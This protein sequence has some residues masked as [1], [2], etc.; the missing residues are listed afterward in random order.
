MYS[1][2]LTQYTCDVDY[3]NWLFWWI[4]SHFW[5]VSSSTSGWSVHSLGIVSPVA[6][7]NRGMHYSCISIL[8]RLDIAYSPRDSDVC[9]QKMPNNA[10]TPQGPIE[11]NR[12]KQ[13]HSIV[14]RQQTNIRILRELGDLSP[15]HFWG[16]KKLL[17]L[18]CPPAK[19]CHQWDHQVASSAE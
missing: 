13:H 9:Q 10:V 12:V 7:Q 11:R 15:V 19:S 18:I 14:G 4:Y 3:P 17:A 16:M 2:N 5:E 8:R 1:N 6:H